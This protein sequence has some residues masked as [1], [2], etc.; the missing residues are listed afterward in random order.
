MPTKTLLTVAEAAKRVG[1]SR[2]TIFEKIKRGQLSATVNHDGNKVVD[3]SELLRVFG[4][5]LSD[6]DVKKNQANKARQSPATPLTST[7]QLE[8]E[9]AKFQLEK[10]DFELEQLRQRMDE[11]KE[12]ERISTEERLRLF[13][14][15]ERQSLLLSAPKP[16]RPAVT[17]SATKGAPKAPTQAAVTK[18]PA[19]APMQTPAAKT[20]AKALSRKP[21]QPANTK[22]L[23]DKATSDKKSRK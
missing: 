16:A 15:I 4:T 17:K 9:R 1:K 19:K 5:L 23:K 11:M 3:V 12:R 7:L 8:L 14:I 18:T 6:D 2:Q 20:P 22:G 10:R 21:S 13:G